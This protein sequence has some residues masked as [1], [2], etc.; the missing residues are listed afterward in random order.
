M[1]INNNIWNEKKID[2]DKN[3]EWYI[4]RVGSNAKNKIIILE[5]FFGKWLIKTKYKQIIKK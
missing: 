2:S 1:K 4:K 3:E 5:T